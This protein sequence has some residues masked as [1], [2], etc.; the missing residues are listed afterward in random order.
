MPMRSLEEIVRR[1]TNRIKGALPI[2]AV[3]CLIFLFPFHADS[4][5]PKLKMHNK[6]RV[7]KQEVQKYIPTGTAIEVAKQIMEANGFTCTL[8]EKADFAEMEGNGDL[9][10][11]HGAIDYLYCDKEKGGLFCARRWQI[12]IVHEN[13]VVS[14][15]LVS[16][17]LIC[18]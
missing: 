16:I 18:L 17:G 7:M 8:K 9:V 4:K 1:S 12:A 2:C 3:S 14:D 5:T 10:A 15:I 13:G 6:T 11:R